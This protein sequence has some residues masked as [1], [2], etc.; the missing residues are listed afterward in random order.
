[1]HKTWIL[2]LASL[3]AMAPAAFAQ[4]ASN[5]GGWRTPSSSS[6]RGWSTRSRGPVRGNVRVRHGAANSGHRGGV[7]VQRDRSRRG[8]YGRSTRHFSSRPF[9]SRRSRGR[10][11]GI[12]IDTRGGVSFR[13]RVPGGSVRVDSRGGVSYRGRTPTGRVHVRTGQRSTS[14]RYRDRHVD[15]SRR[16]TAPAPRR[17]CPPQVV[18]QSPRPN[19]SGA[20]V[21]IR[22]PAP[23]RRVVI[24]TD[25]DEPQPAP[26]PVVTRVEAVPSGSRTFRTTRPQLDPNAPRAGGRTSLADRLLDR[27]S[28]GD[29]AAACEV[30]AWAKDDPRRED[31]LRRAIFA[32]FP[33]PTLLR[34]SAERLQADVD[35]YD[36][37]GRATLARLLTANE[38]P[39]PR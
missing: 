21:I 2:A 11:S 36:H 33:S 24:V 26:E 19:A 20:P 38:L 13:A 32:R 4:R 27:L 12:T 6:Q 29:L 37:P 25:E 17:D 5:R 22:S 35:S 23:R 7:R 30:A 39:L 3:A 14:L 31:M 16:W 1:M 28:A 10:R 18:I 34:D 8:T 15:Y 9:T